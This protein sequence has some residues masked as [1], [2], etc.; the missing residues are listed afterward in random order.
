MNHQN[1]KVLQGFL[2]L[3]F[4]QRGVNNLLEQVQRFS[5]FKQPVHSASKPLPS[6][7]VL[8]L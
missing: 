4:T 3:D 1:I 6:L 2:L 5:V 8:L 7:H